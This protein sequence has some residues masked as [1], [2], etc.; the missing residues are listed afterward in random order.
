MNYEP[1]S[2]MMRLGTPNRLTRPLMKLDRGAC[3][4]GADGFY[5]C[6]LG[7]L[8]DGDVEVSVAPRRSGE[9]A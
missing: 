2:V 1:L 4:D 5:L 8:V 9:R 3:R 7:E 6:P